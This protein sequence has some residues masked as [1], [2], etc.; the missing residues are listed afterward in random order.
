MFENIQNPEQRKRTE[1]FA[2]LYK[3]FCKVLQRKCFEYGALEGLD[4]SIN[5]VLFGVTEY[6]FFDGNIPFETYIEQDPKLAAEL[7]L[8]KGYQTE[9]QVMYARS[10]IIET[11]LGGLECAVSSEK[12][13]M[14]YRL[15]LEKKT[16]TDP[17]YGFSKRELML[18]AGLYDKFRKY[19]KTE[20]NSL[21][22]ESEMS[23]EDNLEAI[24]NKEEP[25][26]FE[27]AQRQ[28]YIRKRKE[29]ISETDF[30][31]IQAYQMFMKNYDLA[32]KIARDAFEEVLQ[33]NKEEISRLFA[34][35]KGDEK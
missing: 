30:M 10:V 17:K 34:K 11:L 9:E 21:T 22:V 33:E 19:I 1:Y 18:I 16:D 28:E 25:V 6:E 8:I 24:S 13:I 3:Q 32:Y 5:G 2:E 27:E 14:D 35:I 15:S 26:S 7:R 29:I 23:L 20:T 12:E 31:R 4:K